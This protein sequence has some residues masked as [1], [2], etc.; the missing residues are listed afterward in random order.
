MQPL[1]LIQISGKILQDFK[2]NTFKK[3]SLLGSLTKH[4]TKDGSLSLRSSYFNE[5]FHSIEG[6]RKE[7]DEKYIRPAEL[8]LYPKH[9][10]INVL[11]ICVGLGYNIA[12]LLN[13]IKGTNIDLNWLGLEI[14]PRPLSIALESKNFISNWDENTFNQLQS[15]SREGEWQYKNNKGRIIWADA[16][17]S[18]K[19]IP[20]GRKFDLIML[21]AF[22][23]CK[24]PELWSEDFLLAISKLLKEGGRITTYSRAAAVRASLKRAGLY[25]M[26]LKA[27][28][29]EKNHWSAGTVSFL[30]TKVEQK[31]CSNNILVR[32]SPMEEE[33]LL[34]K[35]AVPYRDS[36]GS[37]TKEEIFQLR[38]K[39][40][41]DSQLEETKEWKLRWGLLH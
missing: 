28:E 1:S 26:S 17:E 21:D 9:Y 18:I 19:R 34:T 16:R 6:A 40:Q 39:E 10:Q 35:A 33:H 2:N 15:L 20:K 32:L 24:C 5:A 7:S 14:D 13:E 36:S 3:K 37:S 25:V 8:Q 38:E 23:P 12:S 11:D 27:S 31:Y 41:F 22:S 4:L 29:K 30:S